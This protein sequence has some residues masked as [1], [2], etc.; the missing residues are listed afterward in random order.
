MRVRTLIIYIVGLPLLLVNLAL[1]VLEF[2]YGEAHIRNDLIGNLQE[3]ADYRSIKLNAFFVQVMETAQSQ[4]GFTAINR[5]LG[6]DRLFTQLERP[7][8]RVSQVHAMGIAFDA[9]Q[10]DANQEFFAPFVSRDQGGLIQHTFLSP[11]YNFNYLQSQWFVGVRNYGKGLWTLPH[12]DN[13]VHAVPVVTYATPIMDNGQFLGAVHLE[14]DLA[15]IRSLLES[16]QTNSMDFAI[17]TKKGEFIVLPSYG[18]GTSGSLLPDL[19]TLESESKRYNKPELALLAEKIKQGL[20]NGYTKVVNPDGEVVWF[21]HSTIESTDWMLLLILPET[22][23]MKPLR[24]SMYERLMLLGVGALLLFGVIFWLIDRNVSRPIARL[25]RATNALAGGDLDTR[26]EP[27]QASLEISELAKAFNSMG[28]SLKRNIEQQLEESSARMAA[29][30]SSQAKSEFLARMSHEIRTPM[31]AIVGMAYLCLLTEL[32]PKQQDY[33]NKIQSAAGN[34]LR[35]IN[36][37]LDFSKIEAGRMEIESIPYRLSDVLNDLN[38]LVTIKAGEKGLEVLFRVE[39]S[40]PEFFVGDPL[41]LS[42]ILLN[43]ATNALKFTESGEIIIGVDCK[44]QNAKQAMLHFSVRDTG[45]GM[46]QEQ[47]AKLFQSFSQADDSVTRKYGGTGLGLAISKRLVEL[48]GGEVWVESQVSVG[49]TFHCLLPVLLGDEA[50]MAPENADLRG[51]KALVVDDNA[52]AREIFSE[53]LDGF[54]LLCDTVSSGEEAVGRVS[55]ALAEGSPY[56]L[57]L[58]DWQMPFMDGLET[59]RHMRG[60]LGPD[61]HT[62]IFLMSSYDLDDKNLIS[63]DLRIQGRLVKPITPSTLLDALVRAFGVKD[64]DKKKGQQDGLP[65]EMGGAIRKA[66]ILLVEDNE[67]NQQIAIELLER[68]GAQVTVANNGV[69]AVAYAGEQPFDAILMDIQMPLMDGLEAAQKIRAMQHCTQPAVPQKV[70]DGS[71]PIIAMTAHAMSSDKEKSLEA[72]MNDHITKPINPA[73]LYQSLQHWL[74]CNINS[75]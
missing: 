13:S 7:L 27:G 40:V 17:I 54:G 51:L 56:D 28:V 37:I 22:L 3:M 45:I 42:Q 20:P 32:T 44:E 65:E 19:H 46:S 30:A 70:R 75:K 62:V 63:E 12:K 66:R 68:A 50:E 29:E 53:M 71:L 31:N 33:L 55:H 4:A 9:F 2:R 48:M 67:I 15:S 58:S 35:I 52:S 21:G 41:R 26:M 18:R 72:G 60:K 43:L 69:E 5:N 24:E 57:V 64:E 38:A 10:K 74:T 34:L 8:K 23:A 59:I 11:E 47:L 73:E 36:D 49:S 61:D 25:T 39:P 16:V 14:V 6:V 1:M